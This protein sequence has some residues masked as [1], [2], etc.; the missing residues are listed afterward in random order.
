MYTERLCIALLVCV[1]INGGVLPSGRAMAQAKSGEK[2][3]EELADG[4]ARERS[5]NISL[6]KVDWRSPT[7]KVKAPEYTFRNV[8]QNI[9][10]TPPEWHVITVSYETSPEWLDRVVVNYHVLLLNEKK[11]YGGDKKGYGTE[12]GKPTRPEARKEREPEAK[13]TP[14]TLL[15]GSVSYVDVPSKNSAGQAGH[16]STIFIRPSTLERYGDPVA[17]GVEI[18]V[19][20]E[21]VAKNDF[22]ATSKLSADTRKHGQWW[23]LIAKDE[24]VTVRS[25][26]LF[27]R[28][29]TPF[30]LANYL[31]EESI[32]QH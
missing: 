25:D 21:S 7:C 31:D 4:S 10:K 30:V 3:S 24:K 8:M 29:E 23:T 32:Q 26:C 2:K 5:K 17:I 14:Y 6:K 1:L 20:E 9:S 27:N 13:A 18:S 12:V 28:S 19:G 15:E 16:I 11:G 22:S